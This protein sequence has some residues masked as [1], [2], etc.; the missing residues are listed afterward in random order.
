MTLF[1]L[2]IQRNKIT[3]EPMLQMVFAGECLSCK[4]LNEHKNFVNFFCFVFFVSVYTYFRLIKG[5]NNLAVEVA[6]RMEPYEFVTII[7]QQKIFQT[8]NKRSLQ[9]IFQMACVLHI[10]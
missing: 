9:F 3:K 1:R 7:S 2:F 5:E 6:R 10:F 8:S 4:I